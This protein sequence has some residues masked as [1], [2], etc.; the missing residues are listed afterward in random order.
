MRSFYVVKNTLVKPSLSIN[1]GVS[2]IEGFTTEGFQCIY[3][4]NTKFKMV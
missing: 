3:I 1:E 4:L 2:I